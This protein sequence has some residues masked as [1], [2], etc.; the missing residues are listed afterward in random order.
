MTL[1]M[2]AGRIRVGVVIKAAMKWN[3]GMEWDS[4][5]GSTLFPIVTNSSNC[6]LSSIYINA[7]NRILKVSN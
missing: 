2:P 6:G 4:W 1:N 7:K 3:T 5:Q